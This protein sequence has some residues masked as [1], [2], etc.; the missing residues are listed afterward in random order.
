MLNNGASVSTHFHGVPSAYRSSAPPGRPRW[1]SS[2]ALLG[3]S[4]IVFWLTLA[5]AASSHT[6]EFEKGE[7]RWPI[8]TSVPS[9]SDLTKAAE[10][11]LSAFLALANLDLDASQR[12]ALQDERLSDPVTIAGK[13]IH[14]GDIISFDAFLYRSRC[15]KDGDYHLEVGTSATRDGASCVIV[16]IPDPEEISDPQLRAVVQRARDTLET[17]Y[18]DSEARHSDTE[19]PR[20][21]I[22]G[23]LFYDDVHSRPNEPGGGRGTLLD[24]G[25]HCATNLWE[26]HPVIG[27]SDGSREAA[28]MGPHNVAPRGVR[29][30]LSQKKPVQPGVSMLAVSA[31]WVHESRGTP[32]R[33]LSPVFPSGVLTEMH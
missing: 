3:L 18:A 27:L 28:R 17:D 19:P 15:Q 8:K 32:S 4:L 33:G 13:E 7:A 23:Q 1:Y 21:H 2:R 22:V 24:S 12:A 25:R 31:H 29:H 26:I 14:E 10:V 30:A 16:E 5:R 20:V 11:D 6:C 9:G